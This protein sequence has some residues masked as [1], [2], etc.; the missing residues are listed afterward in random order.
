MN[1]ATLPPLKP[2]ST[3]SASV[4]VAKDALTCNVTL[5]ATAPGPT[6]DLSEATILPNEPVEVDEPLIF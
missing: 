4:V 6:F 2:P 5:F 3:N 1:L